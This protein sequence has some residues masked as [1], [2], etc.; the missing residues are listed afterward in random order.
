[1]ITK[2]EATTK[3]TAEEDAAFALWEQ[4]IDHVLSTHDG[5]SF[6][7]GNIPR[8]VRLRLME[9]YRKAK[10]NIQPAKA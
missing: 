2:Q 10:Q 4:K 6:V 5:R 7:N 3:A 1:V 8:R 9:A